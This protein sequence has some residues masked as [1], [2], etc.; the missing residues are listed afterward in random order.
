[1]GA[2]AE[3]VGEA[4]LVR[5]GQ[6]D[7]GAPIIQSTRVEDGDDPRVHHLRGERDLSGE[8]CTESCMDGQ[9]AAND[10][11]RHVALQMSVLNPVHR[12]GA[13]LADL[14]DQLVAVGEYRC[15]RH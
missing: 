6:R 13:A 11:D 4:A 15:V 1:M 3:L 10:L 5:E 2:L 7:E 9:V 12:A 14:V 8:A